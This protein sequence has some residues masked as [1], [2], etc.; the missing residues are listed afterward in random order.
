ME[1]LFID[2]VCKFSDHQ[3]FIH[4]SLNTYSRHNWIH[5]AMSMLMLGTCC[6]DGP[7]MTSLSILQ[8]CLSLNMFGHLP[9][10]MIHHVFNLS[11]IDQLD[12]ELSKCSSKVW[13]MM[14]SYLWLS[15]NVHIV[16]SSDEDIL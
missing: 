12:E 1:N 15:N 8:M 4:D 16:P 6:R 14:T 3:Y 9:P 7:Q 2:L 13:T 10:N 11:F 5:C